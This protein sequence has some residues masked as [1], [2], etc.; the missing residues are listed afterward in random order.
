MLTVTEVDFNLSLQ[1]VTKLISSLHHACLQLCLQS[2]MTVVLSGLLSLRH[3]NVASRL[4]PCLAQHLYSVA[5]SSTS[6]NARL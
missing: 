5:I 1:L 4:V 6:I 3:S 2:I